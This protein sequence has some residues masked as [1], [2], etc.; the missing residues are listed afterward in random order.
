MSELAP[1][2]HCPT[3]AHR[4]PI[5]PAVAGTL[6]LARHGVDMVSP[7]ALVSAPTTDGRMLTLWADKALAAREI[8]AI[9]PR[10]AGRY[11]QFLTSFARVS[12]V[13]QAVM[14]APPLS[15]D[16]LS[17][18]DLLTLVGAVRKL[19]R[20]DPVDARRLLRWMPMPVA[21][22]ASEWFESEPLL[23]LVAAE[24]LLGAFLGPRSPGSTLPLLLLGARDGHPFSNGC[25]PRG[26]MAALVGA[27]TR[28]AQ[29]A[30]AEIRAGAE[31]RQIL[32]QNGQA[33]GVL[34]ATGEEVG[35]RVVVSSAD[36][37][38]TFGL[39]DQVHL[40]PDFIRRVR[41][42]RMR[43]TLAKVN[44]AVSS[45]PRF[46][47]LERSNED[48]QRARLSGAVRLCPGLTALERAFDAAKYGEIP[49]EPWVE[50]RVPS[51]A[52][53]SLAPQG[54]HV[55][56]A[57]VQFAPFALRHTSWD[58][59]RER[60]GNITTG[61]IASYA[62][63]FPSTVVAREIVTP[64]DLERTYGLTG[65]QIFHGE[66]ALD[67]IALARPF[68]GWTGYEAPIRNLFLCGGGVHPGTGLDGRSGA[69]AAKAIISHVGSQR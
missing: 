3:L 68:L 52:D 58:S 8:A 9:S 28:A 33:S 11:L 26:G 25:L 59:E 15:L 44:Y 7:A 20:L 2:F 32:V 62:P 61:L 60:L 40:A 24:G 34:L 14:S 27:L 12:A 48:D 17:V 67:Q 4:A 51:I 41:G 42:I 5:D 36:P 35:A 45:L 39:V 13:L 16:R 57:Y 54:Q 53:P 55:V 46:A 56:S 23:S 69:L 21:D 38:R 6:D 63:H 37:S 50:L 1:G 29:Q 10:D 65:G 43:G 64:L 22:L 49:S 31:V 47:C 19:R 18:S 66:L 30:G